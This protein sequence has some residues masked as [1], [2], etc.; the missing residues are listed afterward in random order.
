MQS[1]IESY[2]L[3]FQGFRQLLTETNSLV[4]GSAALALYLKQEG[5]DP[6]FTPSDLDIWVEETHDTWHANGRVDVL[7]NSTKFTIFLVKH[8]Y[9]LTTKF[10]SSINDNY[11]AKMSDVKHIFSF[12]NDD[13]KEIQVIMLRCQNL[14]SYIQHY[15]DL[16][17]CISWW[18]ARD[19]V[20]RNSFPGLTCKREIHVLPNFAKEERTLARV[21][22][23]KKRG[24]TV[25]EV[26]CPA[27]SRCD[28]Y[29]N[30]DKLE[31]ENAFD[32][33]AY[34]DVNAAEFLRQSTFH[35][36]L[37]IGKQ[38]YAYHRNTIVQ[39]LR[40]HTYESAD[41]GKL[42][43]LPHKQLIPYEV[44]QFLPYSDYSIIELKQVIDN[45]YYPEYYTTD[46]WAHQTPGQP[47]YLLPHSTAASSAA[48]LAA[49]SAAPSAVPGE[50]NNILHAIMRPR[51]IIRHPLSELAGLTEALSRSG[52]SG[53]NMRR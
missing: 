44:L 9:N 35:V 31:E 19:N 33:F 53:V 1:F 50:V 3:P 4:A 6:G 51:V 39:Y 18:V 46:Q 14:V 16:T 12:I 5:V 28:I 26:P 2:G 45:L 8:G 21:E 42:C 49:P 40:E 36:L 34:D 24:F 23:Y 11:Y 13:H 15:F 22:K 48:P 10:D 17:A 25:R 29:Q 27:L 20:F 30:I 41:Y 37:R 32:V 52:I 43:E 38:F 7:A 47:Q